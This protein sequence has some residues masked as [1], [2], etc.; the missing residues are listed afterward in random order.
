[1]VGDGGGALVGAVPSGAD[2]I[3]R[4]TDLRLPPWGVSMR[5]RLFLSSRTFGVLAVVMAG[6]TLWKE[7]FGAKDKTA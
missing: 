5:W 3:S 1:M 2:D 4:I 6:Y 7:F